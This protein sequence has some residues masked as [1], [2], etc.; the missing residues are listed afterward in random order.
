MF[1]EAFKLHERI[2]IY[3]PWNMTTKKILICRCDPITFQIKR[4]EN[5]QEASEKINLSGEQPVTRSSPK[6]IIY[7][8]EMFQ[9]GKWCY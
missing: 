5:L 7:T 4:R 3:S 9:K 6:E 2:A 1:N 8:R